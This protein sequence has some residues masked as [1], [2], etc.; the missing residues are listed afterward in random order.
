VV[1]HFPFS[2]CFKNHIGHP[3]GS[4]IF[5]FTSIRV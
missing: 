3:A 4:F 1:A 2:P 5:S